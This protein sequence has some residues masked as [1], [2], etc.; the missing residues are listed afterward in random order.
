M[1]PVYHLELLDGFA[2][3]DSDLEE[4][5]RA[6]R[7][8]FAAQGELATLRA[9]NEQAAERRLELES[10]V[11]ELSPF[12]DIAGL[13]TRLEGEIRR[14]ANSEKLVQLGQVAQA[15]LSGD[16][17]M[18][19]LLRKAHSELVEMARLDPELRTLVVEFEGARAALSEVERRLD[20]YVQ[21]LDLNEEL[22]EEHRELLSEL[23]RVERKYRRSDSDLA[24]L[25][26]EAKVQLS[27]QMV[28][29]EEARLTA[30]VESARINAEAI[31]NRLTE[32]R[33]KAAED[34]ARVVLADLK[35]LN[36]GDASLEVRVE[37][38]SLSVTG[39]D[40]VTFLIS[41][42]R[43]EPYKP[44]KDVASGGELSRITLVLKKALRERS[45]VNVLIFDEVDTG[46]SGGVARA[47]GEMLRALAQQ[48]QV[49]CITH[50]PQVASLSDRHFLVSKEVSARAKTVVKVLSDAE[51]I[52]EIARMLAGYEVTDAS[53]ASA[54]ELIASKS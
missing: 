52:D 42:N 7:A 20:R 18:Q 21:K 6:A 16:E 38:A 37:P 29:A 54:R 28:E 9:R 17:A 41:T 45:G 47:V 2:G 43:G 49:V 23:A 11:S 5:Q 46:V 50:L 36:M 44:L 34:L 40:L 13:R 1:D 35:E 33:K 31:A 12:G 8:L 51:K 15:C 25:L 53:R 32:T 24:Q 19:P 3:T 30:L 10:I 27:K 4:M 14:L 48:S 26:E 22:L 39:A